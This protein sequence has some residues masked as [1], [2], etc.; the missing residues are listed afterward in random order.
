MCRK[1]RG[2]RGSQHQ[3]PGPVDDRTFFLGITAPE[4][5]DQAFTPAVQ[6]TDDPVREPFPAL[7]LVR[8]CLTVFDGQ[9]R[10]QQQDPLVCPALQI[11][12]RRPGNTQV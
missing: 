9:Y 4:Q 6:F 1:R 3:V 10:V 2:M 7:A 12:V 8:P 11:A 5:E